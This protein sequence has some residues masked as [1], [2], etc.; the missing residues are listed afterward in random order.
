MAITNLTRNLNFDAVRDKQ[1]YEFELNHA[2]IAVG[3]DNITKIA[4]FDG[5]FV[6]TN[7]TVVTE[8][9]VTPTGRTLDVGIVNSDAA[10]NATIT[11]LTSA[12]AATTANAVASSAANTITRTTQ[13][14]P[15]L[16]C[17]ASGSGALTG[18]KVRVYV[19]GYDANATGPR[20]LNTILSD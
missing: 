9:P 15:T 5:S 2:D 20:R 1:A 16:V 14:A 6:L 8:D 10:G 13:D 7:I 4:V 18:G 12:A 3:S 17:R 19:E 11:R